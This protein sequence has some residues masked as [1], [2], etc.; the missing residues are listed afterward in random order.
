MNPATIDSATFTLAGPGGAAVPGVVTYLVTGSVAIFTPAANL[1]DTTL[2][3]T[4]AI[5]TGAKDLVG[6][7]L[8]SNYAWTF[9][10]RAAPDTTAPTVISTIPANAATAVPINQAVSAIFSKAMNPATIAA[11]TFTLQGLGGA[12]AAGLVT[13][14]AIGDVAIFTPAT[15]LAANTVF[16]GTITTGAKDLSGNALA[17]NYVWTFTTGATLDA[18]QPEILST[19][20]VNAATNVPINQ[21][22]SATFSK[23]MNPLT[24]TTATAQLTGPGGT[25]IAATVAY[26]PIN[27]IATLTPTAS[28]T[29]SST[30]IA[31]ITRGA[32]DLAGNALGNGGAPNPW[33]FTTGVGAIPPPVA[34]GT[35]ALF[36]GFSGGAGMTNQGTATVVNGDIG[37]TGVSTSITGFNDSGP[38]CVYTETPLNVGQVNGSIDTAAPPPTVACPTEG[39]AVTVAIAAQAAAD[40]LT[41]YNQLVAFPGG[42]D[43][44][45]CPGAEGFCERVGGANPRRRYLHGCPG[46]L[47]HNPRGPYSRRSGQSQ[48]VLGIPDGDDAHSRHTGLQ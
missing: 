16:T 8:A 44:S 39:T 45:T 21:A 19:V 29:A 14:S 34:L 7:A 37:T 35:A 25:S 23:A 20:P 26:D 43:V 2:L 47:C 31:T 41:A 30:H 48:C 33:S 38:G 32:A 5:T 9:T 13:Y 42:L 3:Y 10:T 11:A 46:K 17:C 1:A 6:N 24:I 36:G 27:F 12:A 18:T 40:A 22:I 15:N 4:A 28:L